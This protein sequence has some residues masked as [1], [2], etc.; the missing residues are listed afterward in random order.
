[1]TDVYVILSLITRRKAWPN[2]ELLRLVISVIV[3]ED[4]LDI[5][6]EVCCGIFGTKSCV[7]VIA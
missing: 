5:E 7:R 6:R 3:I 1:M 4:A 2:A